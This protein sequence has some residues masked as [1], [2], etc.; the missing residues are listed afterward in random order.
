MHAHIGV[1]STEELGADGIRQA[2]HLTRERVLHDARDYM[3]RLNKHMAW[4]EEDLFRR[5]AQEIDSIEIDTS[6]LTMLDPIF[7]AQREASFANLLQAI[8]REAQ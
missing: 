8:Q 4:E 1:M 2:R 3:Q 7:G 6:H 5:A